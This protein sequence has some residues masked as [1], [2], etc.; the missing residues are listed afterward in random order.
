[1]SFTKKSKNL[2]NRRLKSRMLLKR[3]ATRSEKYPKTLSTPR[4]R[5]ASL[6]KE[7]TRSI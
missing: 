5:E 3:S 4:K 6:K 2:K 1:M 7:G